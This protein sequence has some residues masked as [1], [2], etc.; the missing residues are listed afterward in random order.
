MPLA[1]PHPGDPAAFRTI[2]T[3]LGWASRDNPWHAD[4]WAGVDRAT[5]ELGAVLPAQQLQP[6]PAPTGGAF[7]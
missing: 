4:F 3:A 7:P 1:R 5:L 6:P 2:N